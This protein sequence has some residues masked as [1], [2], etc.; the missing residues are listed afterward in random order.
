MDTSLTI[1]PRDPVTRNAR[2]RPSV[3]RTE[4]APTQSVKPAAAVDLPHQPTHPQDSVGRDLVDPQSRDVIYRARE[5]RERNRRR[6]PPDQALMRQ[7]AYGRAVTPDNEASEQ[8]E[9]HADF[10]V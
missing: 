5:E 8:P 9:G 1:K 6:R 4:I 7:R 10:E 3:A 2:A